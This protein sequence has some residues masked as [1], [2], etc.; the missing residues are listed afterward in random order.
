MKIPPHYS[1]V[2]VVVILVLG[3]VGLSIFGLYHFSSPRESGDKAIEIQ[4][5]KGV[6]AEEARELAARRLHRERFIR[7]RFAFQWA[8]SWTD[9]T[10]EPGRYH[11]PSG[12]SVLALAREFK[13]RDEIWVTIPEGVRKEEIAEI[14]ADE[15]HWTHRQQRAFLERHTGQRTDVRIA[16]Y[17]EGVYFPDTYLF[18]VNATPRTISE[19]LVSRFNEQFEPYQE[20]ALEQNIRWD[21]VLTLASLVQREAA[22]NGDM[23]LVAG[24]LWN[25]LDEG[26]PLQIDATLQYIAG[27]ES[28][29]WWP[30]VTPDE[31]ATSSPFNTY[32]NTGI[33]PHPI[34]NPGVDAI[35]AVLNPRETQC[36]YY[37]HADRQIYCAQTYREHRR[38]IERYLR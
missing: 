5:N 20:E 17:I 15:F 1:F 26:M 24:I 33:P 7:S 8:L 35:A 32:T 21:T 31:V 4:I 11:I 22:G 6:T 2:A 19:R 38:N 13:N 28:N 3:T 12:L 9:T 30:Q 14:L 37:I 29:G 36:I 34:A 18:P 10:I 16:E 27:S 25:R 23:P